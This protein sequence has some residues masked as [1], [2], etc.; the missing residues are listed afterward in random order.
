[1]R[2]AGFWTDAN[3]PR[4]EA[5]QPGHGIEPRGNGREIF[6][7][8]QIGP[9]GAGDMTRNRQRRAAAVLLAENDAEVLV[10]FAVFHEQPQRLAA[11]AQFNAKDWFA[12]G[13]FGVFKEIHGAIKPAL[14]GERDRGKF[15]ANGELQYH[16][17]GQGG[18][19]E[20]VVA[21]DIEG[22]VGLDPWGENGNYKSGRWRCR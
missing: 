6:F 19:Q 16:V 10:T 15:V 9:G 11:N 4:G 18:V 1:M 7:L 17:N 13:R 21:V 5:L 14:V 3:Q 22:N 12:A 20:G 8:E 2:K